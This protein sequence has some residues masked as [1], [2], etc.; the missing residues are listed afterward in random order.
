MNQSVTQ[1]PVPSSMNLAPALEQI[2]ILRLIF[3]F[4]DQ[5]SLSSAARV[6][7]AWSEIALDQLWR[8]LPSIFPLIKLLAPLNWILDATQYHQSLLSSLANADW[9]RFR[10][11]A[12]RV[13]CVNADYEFKADLPLDSAALVQM[14]CRTAPLLPNVQRVSWKFVQSKNCTSILPFIGPQLEKLALVM[15]RGIDED[16]QILLMQSLRNLVPNL[17]SLRLASFVTAER[18]STSLA[19]LISSC[20]KLLHLE[21]PAGFLTR[22]V[23]GTT[24][25]L[26]LLT[27]LNYSDW[28]NTCETY[29][30]SGM[31]F[32]FT[33]G[34]FPQLDTLSFAALPNRMTKVLRSTDHIGRLQVICLDCPAFASSNQIE[35]VLAQLAAG[36]QRLVDLQLVCSPIDQL[37]N[38][39]GDPSLSTEHIVP[40]FSCTR[41][42]R[43]HLVAP[44]FAPLTDED[45]VD[46]GRSWPAMRSLTLCPAPLKDQHLG[47]GF[48]I[49]SAFAENLPNLRKLGLFLGPG[50]SEFDG[51]LYPTHRFRCLETLGVG[52]SIVPRGKAQEVGFLLASLCQNALAIEVGITKYHRGEDIPV[53]QKSDLQAGWS[54]VNSAMNLAF[55]TKRSSARRL[56]TME[57]YAERG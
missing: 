47:T 32:E 43:L 51:N 1:T 29:H 45:V 5:A 26:P 41:L 15:D 3:Q 7:R 21:L 49:L 4:A 13:R 25:R 38:P 31:Y 27:K 53:Q 46:M 16:E 37:K 14:F 22:R 12:L 11:Y 55:R 52:F 6:S 30:Q 50:V 24:A 19:A 10:G 9:H 42:E 35:Q 23:V 39:H 36:A 33:P 57:P 18:T 56:S 34:S 28:R 20:P 17:R 8:S 44:H 48:N 2:R 40:L 54:E